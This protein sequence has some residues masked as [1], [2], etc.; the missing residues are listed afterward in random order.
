MANE[1]AWS[2]L[3][4]PLKY[5]EPDYDV[6]RARHLSDAPSESHASLVSFGEDEDFEQ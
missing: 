5:T 4:S 3:N 6:A 2:P 1:L